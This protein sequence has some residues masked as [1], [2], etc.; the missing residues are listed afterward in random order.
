MKLKAKKIVVIGLPGAGKTYLAERLVKKIDGAHLN[1]DEVRSKYDDWDFSDEG[2]LRQ[3]NRMKTLAESHIQAGRHVVVDFVCPTPE[4]RTAFNADVTIWV[5]TI[6]KGRFEDTNKVFIPPTEDEYDFH[7]TEKTDG[8]FWP[9]YI[10]KRILETGWD[11]KAPT[12]QLLGRWQPWHEGHRALFKRAIE[13]TGQVAVMIRDCQGLGDNPFC[14]DTAG[15]LIRNNLQDM[16]EEGI[17]YIILP[18]PNITHITYGRTVGYTI[19]QEHF[20]KDIEDVSATKK[21]E[22]LREEG[23]LE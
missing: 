20:E 12:V 13:K 21:R 1:A 14:Q 3:S 6:T 23:K 5:D 22:A 11:S 16:Y 18:V 4:T 9:T 2:R 10:A 19:A 17:D 8:D 15:D 7:V